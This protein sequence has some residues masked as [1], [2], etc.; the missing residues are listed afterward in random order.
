[1]LF[2]TMALLAMA[3][4]LTGCVSAGI[5]RADV[6]MKE[7]CVLVITESIDNLTC[8]KTFVLLPHDGLSARHSVVVPAGEQA[9]VVEKR[10]RYTLA[11]G[12]TANTQWTTFIPY[13]EKWSV[14]YDFK[15]G[16]SYKMK[17]TN[18]N[19]S[20]LQ[21]GSLVTDTPGVRITREADRILVTHQ[22]DIEI[23]EYS[24]GPGGGMAGTTY[25]GP[26]FNAVF[27]IPFWEY[28][29]GA[30]G[31]DFGPRLGLQLIHG[32]FGMILAG[33]AAA[34]AYISFPQFNSLDVGA[35]Y[36]YGGMVE[37]HFPYIG[38][39]FG[40]GMTRGLV[41][42]THIGDQDDPSEFY[43]FPYA[44]FDLLFPGEYMVKLGSGAGVYA[45]YYFNDSPNWYNKFSI[46]IKSHS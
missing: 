19:L 7:S 18:V 25:V 4:L 22:G 32:K 29:P 40:G 26:Y 44:E 23:E 3:A 10:K 1:M 41:N 36:N 6:P 16:K 33:E 20:T 28:G 11:T 30:T 17:R 27:N 24:F 31:F 34:G 13:T 12:Q 5:A 15:P 39:G 46:G 43:T 42:L 45:R 2:W 8:G 14:T 37:F 9:L 35:A 21:D 38:L